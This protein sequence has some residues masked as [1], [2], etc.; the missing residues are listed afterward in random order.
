MI[1]DKANMFTDG[2]QAITASA[3]SEDSLNWEIANPNKG[4]G[5]PLYARVVVTEDFAGAGASMTVAI[6]DSADG[7]TWAAI[8]TGGSIGVADL[9]AGKKILVPLPKENR[10][11]IR[12]YFTVASGPFTAGEVVADLTAEE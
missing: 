1:Q 4:E 8:M 6:Q 9:V 10:K 11:F 7:S 5:T 3:A 2:A 12:L